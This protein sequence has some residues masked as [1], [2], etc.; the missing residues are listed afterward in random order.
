RP[1]RLPVRA[2]RRRSH[3][4]LARRARGLPR[5]SPRTGGARM[6][7][8]MTG[9][10][11][12]LG[13]SVAGVLAE[14]GH[15]ITVLRRPGREGGLPAGCRVVTGDLRDA[16]SL[17]RALEGREALV[18]MAAMVQKWAADR[19]EFDRVNVTGTETLLDAASRAGVRRILYTSSVVA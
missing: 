4:P 3:A 10:T 6:K 8:L 11:G 1:R 14:A 5:P 16:A 15:E 19:A 12:Y 13:G 9:A 2:A 7:V 18:H 17:R